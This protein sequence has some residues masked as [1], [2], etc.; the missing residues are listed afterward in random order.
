MEKQIPL[1]TD[2]G[3]PEKVKYFCKECNQPA[4]AKDYD[5][6][7]A[8]LKLCDDCSPVDISEELHLPKQREKDVWTR[9]FKEKILEGRK[10]VN[11][12]NT[13]TRKIK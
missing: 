3:P 13:R 1:E 11:R 12:R 8:K 2:V 9:E 10:N 5:E 6:I 4:F 7:I